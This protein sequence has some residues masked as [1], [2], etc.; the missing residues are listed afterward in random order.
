[1]IIFGLITHT[2]GPMG[3]KYYSG[4]KKTLKLRPNLKYYVKYSCDAIHKSRGTKFTKTTTKT[5]FN[6]SK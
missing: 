6:I 4:T 5:L 3:L 1:M 2:I